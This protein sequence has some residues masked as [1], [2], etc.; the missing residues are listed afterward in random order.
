MIRRTVNQWRDL[1]KQAG[2]DL[3]ERIAEAE[4][5]RKGANSFAVFVTVADAVASG[6]DELLREAVEVVDG[7]FT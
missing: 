5:R 6:D 3:R 7:A 1:W 4:S 2:P